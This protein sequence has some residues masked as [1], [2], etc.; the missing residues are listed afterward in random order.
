MTG[1]PPGT[2]TFT[3]GLYK[4]I[5]IA[6]PIKRGLDAD[7]LQRAAGAFGGKRKF[8]N[9][10]SKWHIRIG[11]PDMDLEPVFLSEFEKFVKGR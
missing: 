11:D 4:G 6:E 7:F 1:V 10:V 3:T 9:L 2:A 5:T 8:L